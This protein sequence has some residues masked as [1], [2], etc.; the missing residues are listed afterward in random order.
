MTAVPCPATGDDGRDA[1]TVTDAAGALGLSTPGS[2][3]RAHAPRRLRVARSDAWSGA[4]GSKGHSSRT[5]CR[6]TIQMK[7]GAPITAVTMPTWISSEDG[8]M[9]RP[10]M[11]LANSSAAPARAEKGS[12]QR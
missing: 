10:T 8:A 11:S 12:S 4:R 3:S 2:L 6:R 9:V 7:N 5:F 1:V